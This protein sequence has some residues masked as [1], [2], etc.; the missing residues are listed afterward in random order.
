M[1]RQWTLVGFL[2][3]C[4]HFPDGPDWSDSGVI[5]SGFVTN[6]IMTNAK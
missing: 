5:L 3:S 1:F 2:K 4:Y 6:F